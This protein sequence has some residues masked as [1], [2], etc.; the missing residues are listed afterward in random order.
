[1]FIH[2]PDTSTTLFDPLSLRDSLPISDRR[3]VTAR[4][5][6]TSTDPRSFTSSPTETSRAAPCCNRT[7]ISGSHRSTAEMD[8]RLQ[9][10]AALR[11]E[12]H[13]SELQSRVDLVCRRLIENT[14]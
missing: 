4:R 13:T 1:T 3:I 12:E 8:V 11:S 2:V 5:A 6:G 14:K 7:S 9:H 10:G